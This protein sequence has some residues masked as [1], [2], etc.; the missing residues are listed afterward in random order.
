MVVFFKK[1]PI[2]SSQLKPIIAS[3]KMKAISYHGFSVVPPPSQ[4]HHSKVDSL[5]RVVK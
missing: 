2:T 3:T 1:A 4:V 5:D